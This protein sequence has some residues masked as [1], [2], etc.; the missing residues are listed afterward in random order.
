M[1]TAATL[2]ALGALLAAGAGPVTASARTVSGKERPRIGV[3]FWHDS[4]NDREAF[5]GVQDGFALAG[6]E[7]IFEVREA[8]GDDAEA[9]RALGDFEARGV[10]LVYAMGTG[11]ALLAKAEVRKAPVVFT[12]VT[13]P[14]G[15]GVVEGEAG[16]GRNLCGNAGGVDPARALAVFRDALPRLANLAVVF[17]PANPVSRREVEVMR[18]AGAALDPPVALVERPASAEDLRRPGAVREACA[19]VLAK[20]DALW[21]PIDIEVYSR[22]AQAGEAAA[23]A[24]RPVFST[25]SAAARTAA[26]VCL[27]PDLRAVGRASV[28][29]AAR[30]LRGEDPGRIPLLRPRS[31]RVILNLE[32][33]ARTG[34]EMPLPL[35]ASADEFAG[36]AGG[37]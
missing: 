37:R 2:A 22:A 29:A 23:A 16:S 13:D 34:F 35:L 14:V 7:P 18:A 4:P 11:A 12:A 30:V 6:Y 15:S 10:D 25:A 9:R 32:A 33:A 8:R 21:I 24:R 17:D 26:A 27:T 5:Q 28:V 19:A 36:V 1:R 3:L 20:A 31:S